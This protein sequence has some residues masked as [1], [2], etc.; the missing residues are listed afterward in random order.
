MS[1]SRKMAEV[2]R[3][4]TVVLMLAVFTVSVGFGVVL[5]LLPYLIERL[6]GSG[7]VTR[8][9]RH[10]G[11]LTATYTL[12]LFLF[13]PLWG[14]L[15][16]R[17]GP[18]NVLLFG[19]LGFSSTM[20]VFS[21]VE[22]LTAIY[23][24]RFLSGMFAAAV[25]PVAAATIAGA[26]A[27]EQERARRLAFVSMAGISGF[28]LGP[29]VSV[30]VTRFASVLFSLARPAGSVAASLTTT[31]LLALL[32]A[33]AIVFVLPSG[34]TRNR[35]EKSSLTVVG[36]TPWVLPTLL[37]L[38]FIV[39]AGIGVFEVGLALRG[40]QELGLTAYQIALMFSECSL[41]MFVMQAIVFAPWFKADRT[42]WLIAPA[43]AV[44][45][46][47][48]AF[49]PRAAD[50]AS[51]LVVI[52]AVASSAGILSPILTYWISAKAG[53]AQGWE[54]GKQTAASSLGVTL[55]SAAGGLLFNVAGFPGASFCLSAGF[56]GL[57][58]LFGLRLARL[59]GPGNSKY[60]FDAE[61][62]FH[63]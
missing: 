29:M 37:I 48:L 10:T 7:D 51:M 57:A 45:A 21:L 39:S 33:T 4:K 34:K 41:V 55:G 17:H 60:G 42:R 19:L 13:A 8:I 52:G 62:R 23:A 54:L 40:K 28:L 43:L 15:A 26:A 49:V 47:G 9:S 22:S 35:P 53:T 18:R 61:L 1:E 38:T 32:V 11:L 20:L 59:L 25:T 5:P 56:T 24:E 16:D 31:A 50:F 3:A 46:T 14:R 30:F 2:P 44:L 12:S 36:S 63:K 6:L 27:T 58:I